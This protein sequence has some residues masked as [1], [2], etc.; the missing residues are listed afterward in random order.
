MSKN[1]N[2]KLFLYLIFFS[3]C[4]NVLRCNSLTA[5]FC[6]VPQELIPMEESEKDQVTKKIKEFLK[7]RDFTAYQGSYP[8]EA[9]S[10]SSKGFLD[11]FI[12]I[13][14]L[15]FHESSREWNFLT[16][17]H[18]DGKS[19]QYFLESFKKEEDGSIKACHYNIPLF[20]YKG[21]VKP[22]EIDTQNIE[23]IYFY[24][25]KIGNRYRPML[26]IKRDKIISVFL[27]QEQ[28][29]S[30]LSMR[31]VENISKKY[32]S[33]L[34]YETTGINELNSQN[35]NVSNNINNIQN[36]K[37]QIQINNR[38]DKLVAEDNA[39]GDLN[40]N[41]VDNKDNQTSD[42]SKPQG[43]E[44]YSWLYKN[45]KR[46]ILFVFVASILGIGTFL[47][48]HRSHSLNNSKLKVP[49][50]KSSAVE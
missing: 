14:N 48:S 25:E 18:C 12:F 21:I 41:L 3:V 50:Q 42:K 23:Y 47:Y 2:Y 17:F 9:Y 33:Y 26:S 35:D 44:V 38:G 13:K 39:L 45:H 31:F 15:L 8:V 27:T 46:K 5:D 30:M 29:S 37:G 36:N 34:T 20:I 19:N 1:R 43:E 28:T 10:L 24:L 7:I 32:N 22:K 6:Q 16:A 40:G 11:G 4:V 49:I